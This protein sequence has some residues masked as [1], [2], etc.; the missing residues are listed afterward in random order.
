M[1]FG[2]RTLIAAL[3]LALATLAPAASAQADAAA[4]LDSLFAKSFNTETPGCAVGVSDKGAVTTRAYGVADL[5]H[6]I[7]NT[8]ETIFESGSVAKQFTAM[9]ILLLEQDGKLKTTDDIRK[10]LPEMPDYGAP[11]TI[12]HLLNHTSGLRDWG[13][14]ALAAGLPRGQRN[15]TQADVLDIASHQ[16]K[17]NYKPGAEYSYTN[18]GYNL[19]AEIVARA[20]GSSFVSFTTARIFAPLGM[21]HTQWRDDYN[22]LVKG[23][24]TA[25]TK[26]GSGYVQDMPFMNVLGNGGMLTTVGDWL[27]WNDAL[28]SARLGAEV[29]AGMTKVGVLNDGKPITY[30]R[31][32]IVQTYRGFKEISHSGGTGGYTTYL[33]RYP[34]QSLSVALMCNTPYPGPLPGEVADLFLPATAATNARAPVAATGLPDPTLYAGMFANAVT[35]FPLSLTSVNGELWL[36]REPAGVRVAEE[37]WVAGNGYSVT[38]SGKDRFVVEEPGGAP[39]T[40]RRVQ[41]LEPG[42]VQLAEYAG[43]YVSQEA[44]A[45]Y[46][47]AIEN[48]QLVVHIDRRPGATIRLAPSYKDAFTASGGRLIRFKR[49]AAGKITVM[50][51]ADGRMRDLEAPRTVAK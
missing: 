12:E 36:P 30:A 16:K 20:S 37:R 33:A 10:Y 49:N 7:V 18:T 26:T 2:A 6:G 44:D 21:T 46:K 25:Y 35:G 32:V 23:R 34:D 50:S 29:T 9:A 3:A 15:F 31:G 1:R 42:A 13:S 27:I 39:P 4:R 48:G 28:T 14:V 24:A 47:V 11:V 40:Y 5:E 19:L 45:S 38:F 51:L 17:L 41:P 22:R 43:A 8:P